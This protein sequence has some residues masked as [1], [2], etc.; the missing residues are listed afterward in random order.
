MGSVISG[1]MNYR[2]AKRQ[3]ERNAEEAKKNRDW[4]QYMSNTAI[5]RRMQDM[6][7]AGINP[8]LAGK[9]DA[10]TPPGSLAHKMENQMQAGLGGAN[11]AMQTIT[12]A[13]NLKLLEAQIAKT[14]SETGLNKA[15]TTLTETMDRLQGYNADIRQPAAMAIQTMMAMLPTDN[16]Q[17]AARLLKEKA[18]QLIE[19]YGPTALHSAKETMNFIQDFVKTGME[20]LGMQ[21]DT[22]DPNADT[23]EK[24]GRRKHMAEY[25]RYKERA[26][27]KGKN[28]RTGSIP[29]RQTKTMSYEE[30]LKAKGYQR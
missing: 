22:P 10:S 9:Y 7:A 12:Q 26:N 4:Q 13:K 17:E 15:N 23:P 2:G 19:Q 27:N 6:K 24:E 11:S 1:I 16:P 14:E 28:N 20:M 25:L 21:E 3:N 29:G 8:I 5:Q 18:N 30:W